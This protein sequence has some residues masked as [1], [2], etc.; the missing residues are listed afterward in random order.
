MLLLFQRV[1]MPCAHIHLI[2][3]FPM[4]GHI[5]IGTQQISYIQLNVG[6]VLKF[7][8]TPS[9]VTDYSLCSWDHCHAFK[10][11]DISS[12]LAPL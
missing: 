11:E 4:D 10:S 12:Y 2:H 7:N 6:Q 8:A 9:I 5:C 3:C 1:N